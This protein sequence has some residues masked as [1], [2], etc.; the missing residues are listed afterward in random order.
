VGTLWQLRRL[1]YSLAAGCAVAL[2]PKLMAYWPESGILDTLKFSIGFLMLP[3]IFV[4]LIVSAGGVHDVNL[5]VV[6][7]ANVVFYSA[8]WYFLFTH[9]AKTR[10]KSTP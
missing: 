2:L 4:G 5:W 10:S 6:D 8:L 9:F 7:T 3:G 1:S